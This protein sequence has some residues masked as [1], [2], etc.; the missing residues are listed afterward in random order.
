[1]KDQI[2]QSFFEKLDEHKKEETYRV[3]PFIKNGLLTFST[4]KR[5]QITGMRGGPLSMGFQ[6]LGA[7]GPQ[8]LKIFSPPSPGGGGG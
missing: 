6:G 2:A 1:M 3:I 7:F 8:P 5:S 4:S